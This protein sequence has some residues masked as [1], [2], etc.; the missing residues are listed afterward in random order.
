MPEPWEVDTYG[1]DTEDDKT[2]DLALPSG[3]AD[4][5]TVGQVDDESKN[6][7]PVGTH[8]FI[9]KSIQ[10]P[11]ADDETFRPAPQ[12]KKFDAYIGSDKHCYLAYPVT[13]ALQKKDDPTKSVLVFLRTPPVD[14][15]ES[16]MEFYAR[17]T[18]KENGA[19]QGEGWHWRV[20]K[21]FLGHLGFDAVAD[22][23]LEP[24][25]NL[26]RNWKR[27]PDGAMREIVCTV[28]LQKN[29][30]GVERP[31]VK[32]FSFQDA[33]STQ[34]RRKAKKGTVVDAGPPVP[35]GTVNTGNGARTPQGPQPASQAAS[36]AA[37]PV[38]EEFEI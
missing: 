31:G 34:V 28:E 10:I 19:K 32:L 16:S 3:Y 25:A 15:S 23:T 37:S 30:K 1:Q 36:V 35:S 8:T 18:S 21:S 4:H 9:I 33:E 13:V 5:K 22:G 14:D 17:G 12:A 26:T 7:C 11:M 6:E 38:N 24:A 27:W 29:D 2:P 20:Y